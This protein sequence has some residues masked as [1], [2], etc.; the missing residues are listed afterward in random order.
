MFV[1][2]I[3]AIPGPNVHDD[4]PILLMRLDLEELTERESVEIPGFNDRLLQSL[5]GLADHH[6]SKGRPG[7]FVERLVEGTFFGH[8]VEHVALEL[9]DLAGIPVTRGKTRATDRPNVYNVFVTYTC[10]TGMRFLL[11]AAVDLVEALVDEGDYDVASLV[12]EAR[13]V[14]AKSE[15]GPSTRAIVDAARRRNIPVQRLDD[16]SLVQLG[17][18]RQRRLVQTAMTSMTSAVGVDIAGDKKLTTRLLERTGVPVPRGVVVYSEA[19]AVAALERLD[20]PVVVKPLNGNHGRGV[21]VDLESVEQVVAAYRLA[22]EHSDAV[23]V[24]EYLLGRDYRVLVVGGR[25]VAAAERT[26]AHV[27]GDGQH[28]VAELIEIENRDPRRGDGHE[29]P[30]TRLEADGETLACLRRHGL[31]FGSVPASGE[32]VL[33][34]DTANLS[35][36]GSARDVTDIVHPAV[37]IACERAARLFDLDI[38]GIDIVTEAIDQP[39][40]RGGIV[41]VNA[42]PGL[43]MHLHPS[44]GTARDVGGAIV[45]SLFP[46]G[47]SGRVPIVA[48]TGTNGKTTTTRMVA[49]ICAANGAH[50]GMTTTDGIEIDG[51]AIV[52]GDCAGPRSAQTVLADPVVDLAVLETARGGIVRSGLGFD[53][54]DVGIITNVQADHIGEDGAKS[55]EELVDIK[56]VVAERVREGGTIVLGADDENAASIAD[57]PRLAR[58]PRRIVYFSA[59]SGG[60]RVQRH[61]AGGGTAYIVRDGWLIEAEGSVRRPLLQLERVPAT[62]GGAL[63]YQVAN[64]AAAVAASR[65]LGISAE[66]ISRALAR[67]QPSDSAGRLVAYRLGSGHVVID[68]AH[69]A[70]A[71]AALGALVAAWRP[72][73]ATVIVTAP[74]DRAD[75]LLIAAGRAA[76]A[77]FD[78]VI[79]REDADRRG[80]KPGEIAALV[81]RGALA[82]RPDVQCT[83][84][85][86]EEEALRAALSSMIDGELVVHLYEKMEVVRALLSLFGAQPL[87]YD[88]IPRSAATSALPVG[89]DPAAN[90]H[91]RPART[92]PRTRAGGR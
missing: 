68:F 25:L 40:G 76:G 64:V 77:S 4:R 26:P 12:A 78:R 9:S 55:V 91:P 65:A 92:R 15:L 2:S 11:R 32:H 8:I 6:C 38:C 42:A 89:V 43:R 46:P 82:A 61:L 63:T 28:S 57:R 69:N 44:M 67:F 54:S 29:A 18:G 48:I 27:V 71:I 22:R 53:W 37:R 35:A 84:V 19:E 31:R 86:D 13:R 3:H 87:R 59:G 49:A 41:E 34:R 16:D 72:A 80:R 88:E 60:E 74:G 66:V 85:L 20:V 10:E 36:G 45:D 24:E 21:S 33:L 81:E 39:F 5:P 58:L 47:T 17:Y 83:V 51:V 75:D 1:E 50:V 14:V 70:H 73:R 90:S 79:V 30:L 62:L 7:G 56:S 23:L 52:E